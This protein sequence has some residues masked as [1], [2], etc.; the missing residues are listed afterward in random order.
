LCIALREAVNVHLDG[1]RLLCKTTCRLTV[2][3][4][5]RDFFQHGLEELR[6][7]HV[8]RGSVVVEHGDRAVVCL[9][10]H[11]SRILLEPG[12]ADDDVSKDDFHIQR[13]IWR[14]KLLRHP[15]LSIWTTRL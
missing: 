5:V 3:V 2:E 14:Q 7:D 12:H 6:I 15:D 8:Q 13:R 10:E 11:G 1:P 9:R 4:L